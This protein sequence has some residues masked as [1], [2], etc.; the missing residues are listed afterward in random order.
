MLHEQRNKMNKKENHIIK[1]LFPFLKKELGDLVYIDE[2]EVKI[3]E[4]V[5]DGKLVLNNEIIYIETKREVRPIQL[6][7]FFKQKEQL[8]N[9]IVLAN[10]ITPTAMQ[11]LKEKGINYVDG[12]GNIYLKHG[13]V[14]LYINGVPNRPKEIIKKN[15]A[16]TKTGVRVIFQLLII[17]EALNYTYRQIA[18]QAGVALGTVPKVLEGL[19]QEGFVLQLN[20][21]ELTLVEHEQLLKRWCVAYINDLKPTLFVKRYRPVNDLFYTQWEKTPLKNAVWG[22]EPAA[23][24][25]TN[26]LNPEEFTLYTNQ[27]QKEIMIEYKWLPDEN[28]D[29][30]VYEKFWE[31]FENVEKLIPLLTYADLIGTN[32]ARNIETAN[33]I[34]EQYFK[35]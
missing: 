7:R 27:T 10:Y 17:P 6:D 12:V 11:L 22:G 2:Q 23:N 3:K 5:C 4:F 25:L 32:N 15:R 35:K 34:Y 20:K 1:D 19:K 9:L 8:G 30:Y 29:I 21:K 26:Y 28:G 16:F 14:H 24:L 18:K 31:D 13:D 33:I